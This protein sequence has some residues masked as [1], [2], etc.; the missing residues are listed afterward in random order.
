MAFGWVKGEAGVGLGC[1]GGAEAI[2]GCG[3]R[4]IGWFWDI[5]I[6]RCVEGVLG[7]SNMAWVCCMKGLCI[8]VGIT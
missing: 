3:G 5:G 6:E 2:L 7:Y 4:Q 8:L 1:G